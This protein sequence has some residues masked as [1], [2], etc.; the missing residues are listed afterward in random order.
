MET[1]TRHIIDYAEVPAHVPPE[2]VREFDYLSCPPGQNIVDFWKPLHDGP[3]IFFT[4]CNGGHW[5]MTRFDDVAAIL[6]DPRRFSSRFVNVPKSAVPEAMPIIGTDPPLH[7][8]YRRLVAP[9]FSP[10]AIHNLEIRA[11]ALTLQM[12]DGFERRGECDFVADFAFRMPIAIFMSLVDLPE[13]DREEL[14]AISH[15]AIHGGSSVARMEGYRKAYAYLD[16]VIAMRR[17]HPGDDIISALIK[18]RIDGGRAMTHQELLDAGALLL[19]AGLDTVAGMMGWIML[20][21]ARHDGHRRRLAAHPAEIPTAI[22]EL[23]RVYS[24]AN[25]ARVVTEDLTFKGV[26]LKAGDMVLASTSLA[27]LDGHHYPDPE[28]VDFDRA[29]KRSLIFGRGPHQCIGA[30]LA[31]TE[32]RVFLAEWLARIPDFAVAPG[33]QPQVASGSANTVHYLPLVWP[34]D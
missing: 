9:F 3:D 19:V 28:I 4:P 25:N 31:R 18:G 27:A 10:K 30:Y 34:V 22:E 21:L 29:D 26:A 33:K 23:M 32:L 2:L 13:E 17:E 1:L 24:L 6:A 14:L 8:D 7:T 5:V 16:G 12:L 15:Q 20:F 11:R